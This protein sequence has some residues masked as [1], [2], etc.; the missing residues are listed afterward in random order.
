VPWQGE[1]WSA[2]PFL[3]KKEKGSDLTWIMVD[4]GTATVE[5]E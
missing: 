4:D 3:P 1:G 2:I 5:P